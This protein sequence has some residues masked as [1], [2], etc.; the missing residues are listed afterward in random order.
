MAIHDIPGA[1]APSS[2]AA[3]LALLTITDSGGGDALRVVN[4]SVPVISRG[5]S[6]EPYPFD[7]TLPQDDSEQLPRVTLNIS[8]LD[9]HIVEYVRESLEPPHIAIELVSTH[10][11]DYVEVS[12]NFLRL[13]SVSYDAMTVTGQLDVD[14]F[15]TQKFPGES[16][17]PPLFPALFR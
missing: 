3:W 13:G 15:L 9:A 17:V 14:N 10:Y 12:L 1:L 8:N 5:M 11:P 6:F 16:Y 7:I 4:N 2:D